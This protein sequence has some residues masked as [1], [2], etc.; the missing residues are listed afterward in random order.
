MTKWLYKFTI[1]INKIFYGEGKMMTNFV[2]QQM[3][4][5]LGEKKKSKSEVI[6]SFLLS[7]F[8]FF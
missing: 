7:F 5:A 4:T 8:P 1:L 3:D 6:L 2:Y